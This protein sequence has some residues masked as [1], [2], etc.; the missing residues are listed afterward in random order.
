MLII[1]GVV[2]VFTLIMLGLLM[3]GASSEQ[4]RKYEDEQQMKAIRKMEE[5]RKKYIKD[6]NH[7]REIQDYLNCDESTA[8]S[9]LERYS[10]CIDAGITDT[11][12]IAAISRAVDSGWSQE[13][14]MTAARTLKKAGGEAP[15]KMGK[16]AKEDWDFKA[17]NIVRKAGATN[18]DEAV[19]QTNDTLDQFVSFKDDLTSI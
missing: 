17:A 3:K 9:V 18:I 14:A 19:R 11:K 13:K 4:K 8:R 16:K 10:D 1:A 2:L 12:D 6:E 15:G 5:R 7:I